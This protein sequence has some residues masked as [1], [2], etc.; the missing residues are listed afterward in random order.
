MRHGQDHEIGLRQQR[1][2]F[3]GA[4]QFG[5]PRR[6]VA[7]ALVDAQDPHAERRAEPR[8]LA[9]DAADPDDQ[10]GGLGQVDHTLVLPRLP[11]FAAQLLRDVAL[12]AA[13]EGQHK[14]HHMR[15]DM[16][17]VDFA[18]IGDLDRVGD[19]LGIVVAGR[20]GRLRRLQPSEVPG[21]AQQFGRDRAKRGLGGGDRA[22]G[23]GPVLGHHDLHLRQ[24]RG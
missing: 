20:R 3:V 24:S 5:D 14:R 2:Q 18:K 7:A 11:P 10:R 4:V 9:A 1:I 21:L 16:V 8:D 17:V 22:L 23:L 15:A 13:G 12:Q 19:Q 6:L